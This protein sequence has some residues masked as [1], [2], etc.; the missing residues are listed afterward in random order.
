[1]NNKDLFNAINNIDEKFITDAGKYLKNVS[2]FP[3]E[4]PEEFVPMER[5]FSPI[6]L[7]A[8]IAAATAIVVGITLALK[9]INFGINRSPALGMTESGSETADTLD[10]INITSDTVI[11]NAASAPQKNTD[12]NSVQQ[13]STVK[14]ETDRSWDTA[15]T[16]TGDLPFTL[17]GP[18]MVQITYEDITAISGN[19]SPKYL[20]D[21]NW[22]TITCSGFA[23]IADPTGDN[24]NNYNKPEIIEEWAAD[25]SDADRLFAGGADARRIREG[26]MFGNL[27]VNYASCSF[28]RTPTSGMTEK[29]MRDEGFPMSQLFQESHVRFDGELAT[30]GYIVKIDGDVPVYWFFFDMN[31]I[32]LPLMNYVADKNGGFG[33]QPVSESLSGFTYLGELPKVRLSSE[34]EAK[35]GAYFIDTNT[36]RAKVKL[37]DIN[38]HYDAETK[39]SYQIFAETS[40]TEIEGIPYGGVTYNGTLQSI[41]DKAST[42]EELNYILWDEMQLM[43]VEENLAYFRVFRD[44]KVE[45]RRVLEEVTD[46]SP[47]ESG[48]FVYFY[49]NS[50]NVHSQYEYLGSDNQD[51]PNRPVE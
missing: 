23:Y 50:G 41:I 8:P 25:Q 12:E 3:D 46:E 34:Y 33:R 13:P 45:G 26:D 5:K 47:L 35:L 15:D 17:Y 22:L 20:N 48:M 4:E 6:R 7:I 43:Q 51:T 9:T 2:A 18:D 31:E 10:G 24:Y 16:P 49:D 1:M 11:G 42:I 28:W 27:T 30:E 19:V 39:E 21:S 37:S 36:R 40:V 38:I 14:P 29:Q 44:V 32:G